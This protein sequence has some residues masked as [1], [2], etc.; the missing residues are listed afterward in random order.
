MGQNK[1]RTAVERYNIVSA[2]DPSEAAG[3][4]DVETGHFQDIDRIQQ[5][6]SKVCNQRVRVRR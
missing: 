1:T 4:L 3:R 5:A 6:R 2:G